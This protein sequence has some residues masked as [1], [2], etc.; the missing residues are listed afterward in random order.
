MQLNMIIHKILL[1]DDDSI[2]NFVHRKMLNN[3]FPSIPII[4]KENGWLAL[5][6]INSNQD[7]SYLVLLDINMPVMN[8]WKFLDAVDNNINGNK[9]QIHILT[10]SI[11]KS[12]MEKADQY[13]QV[14]SYIQKP[15]KIEKVKEIFSSFN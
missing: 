10:S 13:E 5:Q 2:L 12:D 4:V 11:D 8:G 6:Y 3:L 14:R 9:F 1:I 7:C 15:L